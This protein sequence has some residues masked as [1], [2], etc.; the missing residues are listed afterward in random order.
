VTFLIF[1]KFGFLKVTVFQFFGVPHHHFYLPLAFGP[2]GNKTFFF[3][4][5]THHSQ[6][7][8]QRTQAAARAGGWRARG[9]G[10]LPAPFQQPA[11]A[12]CPP[13]LSEW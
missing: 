7:A 10:T 1:I 4:G 13:L 8:A 12:S 11:R 3:C 9:D 6:K 5:G 2:A